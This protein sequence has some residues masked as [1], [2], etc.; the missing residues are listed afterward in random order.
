MSKRT[1]TELFYDFIEALK[2]AEEGVNAD[3]RGCLTF[4]VLVE[5]A[6]KHKVSAIDLLAAI[7]IGGLDLNLAQ[8]RL[9]IH[10]SLP[11]GVR[12]VDHR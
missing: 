11:M 7:R 12:G 1:N 9:Q 4:E 6:D 8:G 5:I 10:R 2:E 3:G